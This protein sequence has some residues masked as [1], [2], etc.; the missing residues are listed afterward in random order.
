MWP[1]FITSISVTRKADLFS[2]SLNRSARQENTRLVYS[3]PDRERKVSNRESPISL[4][5]AI[6]I[7]RKIT[8]FIARLSDRPRSGAS[9]ERLDDAHAGGSNGRTHLEERERKYRW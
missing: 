2:L 7:D 6:E 9:R 8:K 3:D 1:D 4:G 5:A